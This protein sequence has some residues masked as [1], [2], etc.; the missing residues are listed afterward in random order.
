MSHLLNFKNKIRL[1]TDLNS[2]LHSYFKTPKPFKLQAQRLTQKGILIT[3]FI[4]VFLIF[5]N[6]QRFCPIQHSLTVVTNGSTSFLCEAESIIKPVLYL[7][8]EMK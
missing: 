4:H 8:P 7:F 1:R 6:E 5:P 2:T 3:E